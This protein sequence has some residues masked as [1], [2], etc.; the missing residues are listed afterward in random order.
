MRVFYSFY[1]KTVSRR[2]CQICQRYFNDVNFTQQARESSNFP[3]PDSAVVSFIFPQRGH[4]QTHWKQRDRDESVNFPER[5]P[6]H[7]PVSD[8]ANYLNS[9]RILFL[10]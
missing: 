9:A 2:I 8:I 7:T 5:Q 6:F 10:I 4:I 3:S 1:C